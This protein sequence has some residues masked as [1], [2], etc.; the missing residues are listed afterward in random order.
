MTGPRA[1][2]RK[3]RWLTYLQPA[4]PSDAPRPFLRPSK[5]WVRVMRRAAGPALIHTYARATRRTRSGCTV[6]AIPWCCPKREIGGSR[7]LL[8]LVSDL[9]NVGS[10]VVEIGHG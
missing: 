1:A 6:L 3:R 2:Y 8:L 9:Y 10:V 7:T 4:G 5:G